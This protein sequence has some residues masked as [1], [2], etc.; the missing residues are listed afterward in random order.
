MP[1][2]S[3]FKIY[4]PAEP[5]N[6]TGEKLRETMD[7]IVQER[8]SENGRE[9]DIKGFCVG[10]NG[11]EIFADDERLAKVKRMN[12]GGNRIGDKGA[13]ILAESVTFS[14]LQWLELGGNDIGVEGIKALANAS[15]VLGKLKTLNLYRNSL[16]DAGAKIFAKENKL[17]NLEDIDLAQNEIGDEGLI[18]LSESKAFPH[19]VAI[20]LDNNFTSEEVREEARYGSNFKKLQS[21]NL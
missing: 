4:Q 16:K 5:C 18:A 19:L 15:T 20:Y 6:L 17:V 11:M 2:I 14:K 10:S 21:I 8:L 1:S 9:F 13:K 3:H 7:R 12:L